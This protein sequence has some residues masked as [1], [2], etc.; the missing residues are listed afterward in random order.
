MSDIKALIEAVKEQNLTKVT[1]E[2]YSDEL[3]SLYASMHLRA[4]EVEKAE[5]LYFLDTRTHATVHLSDIEIKRK[6][7]ASNMGLEQIDLNHSLK[8]IEKLLSSVKHRIYST[9]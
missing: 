8:A 6:W 2:Q 4:A 5:A 1:L 3:T 7:K 9:Y